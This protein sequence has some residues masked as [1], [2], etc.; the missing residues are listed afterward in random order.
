M[1]FGHMIQYCTWN[2]LSESFGVTS[3]SFLGMFQQTLSVKADDDTRRS[4]MALTIQPASL[5]GVRVLSVIE[6]SGQGEG[7]FS[8]FKGDLV[9]HGTDPAQSSW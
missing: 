6:F 5:Y 4:V 9:A 8:D 1:C 2:R 3:S 7:I